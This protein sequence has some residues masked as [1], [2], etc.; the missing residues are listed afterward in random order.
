MQCKLKWIVKLLKAHTAHARANEFLIQ[1]EIQN[2]L[3]VAP[4]LVA[5]VWVGVR[6]QQSLLS[7]YPHFRRV[8]RFCLSANQRAICL[9]DK[10][11]QVRRTPDVRFLCRRSARHT[12]SCYSL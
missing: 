2:D 8:D 3:L 4:T 7:I 1:Y 11:C 9:N 10:I 5:G 6:S 12:L